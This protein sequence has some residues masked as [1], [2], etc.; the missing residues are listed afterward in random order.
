[1]NRFYNERPY[2][3]GEYV[4]HLLGEQQVLMKRELREHTGNN[5][6]HVTAEDKER[7]NSTSEA[8]FGSSDPSDGDTS[9]TIIPTKVSDLENDVPYLTTDDMSVY[10]TEEEVRS[11]LDNYVTKDEYEEGE[12]SH[13]SGNDGEY[14]DGDIIDKFQIDDTKAALA[15]AKSVYLAFEDNKLSVK[16]A[17]AQTASINT[18]SGGDV[19][20]F[21]EYGQSATVVAMAGFTNEEMNSVKI[22]SSSDPTPVDVTETKQTTYQVNNMQNPITYTVS[23]TPKDDVP[24]T[25]TKTVYVGR[26]LYIWASSNDSESSIPQNATGILYAGNPAPRP[27]NLQSGQYQYVAYPNIW[28]ISRFIDEGQNQDFAVTEI[29]DHA[30]GYG[31]GDY[32]IIRT[33]QSGLTNKTLKL[34]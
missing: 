27:V 31:Q 7:W 14:V 8:I 23:Y 32:T 9:S 20:N 12:G 19:I 1:M 24:G 18:Y 2:G 4:D 22:Y 5:D 16:V 10:A 3:V 11:W 26:K 6:I 15:G 29:T 25:N 34:A 33:T 30:N 28:G 21:I 17:K 13:Y